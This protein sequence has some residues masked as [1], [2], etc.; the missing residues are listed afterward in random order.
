MP[1]IINQ[2]SLPSEKVYTVTCS[3]C[4]TLFKFKQDEAKYVSDQ[5]DGDFL[6][7][8]CPLPGCYHSVTKYVT[9][10]ANFWDR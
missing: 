10:P 1:E 4:K 9:K 5:R 3:H 8:T 7:I 6:Q 2:G